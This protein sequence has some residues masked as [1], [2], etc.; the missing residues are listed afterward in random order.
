M[1]NP[2][3]I[4]GIMLMIMGLIFTGVGTGVGWQGVYD[5]KDFDENGIRVTAQIHDFQEYTR[6]TSSGT[7]RG[8]HVF[9]IFTT[10]N[11]EE[12]ITQLDHYSTSMRI[13]Q[14]IDIMYHR[15]NP[16]RIYTEGSIKTNIAVFA[17]FGGLGF[18]MLAGAIAI[19]V[20]QIKKKQM[21]KRIKSTGRMIRAN[22]TGIVDDLSIR[23]N[24]VHPQKLEAEFHG[25]VYHSN[26]LSNKEIAAIRMN[27]TVTIYVDRVN[28]K[29]YFVDLETAK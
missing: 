26:H 12:R 28:E 7:T 27:G 24:G 13:G 21:Q 1:K 18:A 5:K 14:N 2:M 16:T 11:G 20:Y 25:T 9:I 23:V 3:I 8:T 17:I 15:Y 29:L 22:I 4:F 19:I 6:K 10:E